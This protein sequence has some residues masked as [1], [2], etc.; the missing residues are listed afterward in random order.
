MKRWILFTMLLAVPFF[1]LA[2][3]EFEMSVVGSMDGATNVHA[4]DVDMD[5][6]IDILG[7]AELGDEIGWWEQTTG[8]W[9]EHILTTSADGAT[10]V[11]TADLNNDGNTDII[12]MSYQDITMLWYGDGAGGFTYYEVPAYEGAKELIPWDVDSDGDLDLFVTNQG[13][14][15]VAWLENIGD[16]TSWPVHEISNSFDGAWGCFV[17]DLDNDGDVDVSAVARYS[18]E[19]AWWENMGGDT[20]TQHTLDTDFD[21]PHGMNGA[22]IDGDGDLDLVAA[23]RNDDAIAMW[24]NDGAGNFTR[25]NI[26]LTSDGADDVHVVDVDMDGDLDIVA[27]VNYADDVVWFE[28]SMDGWT[29]HSIDDNID[30]ATGVYAAD[31]DGDGDMDLMAA[32]YG[33]DEFRL[34]TQLGEPGPVTLT[35]TGTNTTIPAAGGTVMYDAHL[36]SELPGTMPGLR[37]W[38]YVTLPNAQ[39]FGPLMN[40]PFTLTPFMDVTVTDLTQDIPNYAPAGDY[41]FTGYAGVMNNPNLQISDSFMFTKEGAGADASI[42]FNASDWSAA[43]F[44]VAEEAGSTVSLPTE[45]RVSSAYPNPFN[46]ETQLTVYLPETGQ[47]TVNVFNVTGQLVST[48]ANGQVGAGQQVVTFNGANLSSGIYFI[49][50]DFAG[51]GS[52]VQKVTLLK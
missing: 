46:P 11:N 44:S 40:I 33:V 2:Q 39:E 42:P 12:G 3:V 49:Q 24:V 45:F 35:L 52:H 43:G 1:A 50:A 28:Q 25:Q 14:D 7:A 15:Q 26:S 34:Y 32:G 27:A 10:N 5:G 37:F 47:L 8:G 16:P 48:L 38:T 9:V 22:D 18:D 51:Y 6:D 30:G 19:V 13:I 21:Y 29:E 23:A 31:V 4:A 20:W 41:T 36:V 17:G